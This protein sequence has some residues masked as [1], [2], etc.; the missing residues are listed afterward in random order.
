MTNDKIVA[1]AKKLNDQSTAVLIPAL[2][3]DDQDSIPLKIHS[4]GAGIVKS[5]FRN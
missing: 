1:A 5:A 3:T 2:S 4:E